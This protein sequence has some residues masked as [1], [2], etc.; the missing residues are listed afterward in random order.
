MKEILKQLCSIDGVVGYEDDVRHAI[1]E[2]VKPYATEM[3]TDSIGNL[4]VFK[5]G[6]KHRKRPMM[7]CAHMDEVG[8]LVNRITDDGMIKLIP[9][10]GIDP[11]V[12]VGRRMRM[13]STKGI[14]SLKAI[15]LTTV[16]ERK[17]A[18][19]LKD[20]YVDIGSKSK[21]ETEA[22]VSI[23]DPVAFDSDFYDIGDC[24]KG[25]AIDD[26]FGCTVMIKM[27]EKTLP[28]DTYF[29]FTTG[30][31]IGTQGALMAS[32]RLKPGGCLIIEGTTAADL[33]EVE[34]HKQ[35]TR[36]RQ[37]AV[38]SVIDGGTVYNR[39]IREKILAAADKKKIKWQ[40]RQSANGGT[41]AGAIHVS[42][43]GCLAFGL[44]APVRYIHS[45]C[46]MLNMSDAEEVL[47]LAELFNEEVGEL[48]V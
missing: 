14:I 9:A 43:V 27:L 13:G 1:E 33:P 19:P 30:E 39:E 23:G 45:A 18:P 22:K 40:Y 31:E 7:V 38:V 17:T 42:S 16:A 29:V 37:G 5:K 11:R 24:V 8:F 4:I 15:H 48:D 10:G 21:K 46:N 41:D 47:K 25:K 20:L 26:R 44:A 12:L 34:E 35:S 3:Y 6:K 28:Y 2:R 36:H 32:S